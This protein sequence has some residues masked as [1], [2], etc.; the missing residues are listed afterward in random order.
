MPHRRCVR[1]LRSSPWRVRRAGANAGRAVA[2]PER[3]P[4]RWRPVR[5]SSARPRRPPRSR[6]RYTGAR[7]G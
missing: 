6:H 7:C 3:A 4:I 2:R 1:A 5:R